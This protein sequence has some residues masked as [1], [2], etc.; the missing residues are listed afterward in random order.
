M[1]SVVRFLRGGREMREGSIV[2]LCLAT[3]REGDG[4][5]EG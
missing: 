4:E 3:R 5:A 1:F 2:I